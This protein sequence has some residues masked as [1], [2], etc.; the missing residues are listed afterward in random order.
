ML[1]ATKT[2]NFCSKACSIRKRSWKS[3]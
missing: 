3:L 2:L 1:N